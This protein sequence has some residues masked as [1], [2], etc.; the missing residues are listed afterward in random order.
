MASQ[1]NAVT[2]N[3]HLHDPAA[4]TTSAFPRCE[5]GPFVSLRLEP[6]TALLVSDLAVLDA[7]A[8]QVAAAREALAAMLPG[9]APLPGNDQVELVPLVVAR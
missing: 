7:L 5:A 4:I 2:V 1:A 8:V 9:Q 6:V 3:V